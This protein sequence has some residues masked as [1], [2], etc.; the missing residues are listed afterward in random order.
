MQ[1]P[2]RDINC[3][4]PCPR[5]TSEVVTTRSA[6]ALR[7]EVHTLDRWR[8]NDDMVRGLTRFSWVGGWVAF[9]CATAALVLGG[10]SILMNGAVWPGVL[11]AGVAAG[12][13]IATLGRLQKVHDLRANLKASDQRVLRTH[14]TEDTE[15]ET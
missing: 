10:V 4:I 5:D 1:R 8:T 11:V 9:V 7:R 13:M 3:A 12:L 15:D 2:E 6:L 14:I